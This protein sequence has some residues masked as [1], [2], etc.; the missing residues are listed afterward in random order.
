MRNGHG[1]AGERGHGTARRRGTGERR[2][3]SREPRRASIAPDRNGTAPR[4]TAARWGH[5]ALPQRDRTVNGTR[6][7]TAWQMDRATGPDHGAR[8]R[9]RDHGARR[10]DEDI[11]PYRHGT[12]W[13]MDRATGSHGKWTEQRETGGAHGHGT[14]Q[15]EQRRDDNATRGDEAREEWGDKR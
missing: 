10:R 11:A 7:G 14:V 6:N 4:G 13:Q 12:A 9:G 5:R 15:W 2:G 1:G 3:E 8:A